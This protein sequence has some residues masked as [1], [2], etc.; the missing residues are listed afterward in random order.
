MH[1]AVSLG[2]ISTDDAQPQIPVLAG[3][4]AAAAHQSYQS[5]VQLQALAGQG[6]CDNS[7]LHLEV[8][9][10]LLDYVGMASS[11]TA[12]PLHDILHAET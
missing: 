1:Q 7:M 6:H 11:C 12:L 10:G 3:R 8:Y 2:C 5:A 4:A 9:A